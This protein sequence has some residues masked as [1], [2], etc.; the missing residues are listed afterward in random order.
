MNTILV[1]GASGYIAHHAILGLLDKGYAVRGTLRDMSREAEV[2]Q[3]VRIQRDDSQSDDLSFVWADMLENTGWDSAVEGVDAILHIASPIETSQPKDRDAYVPAARGGVLRLLEAAAS[4]GTVKKVVMTSSVAAVC[5]GRSDPDDHIYT[6][7]D[8]S[9]P[10]SDRTSP[11]ARSKTLAERAAWDFMRSN[12]PPFSLTTVLPGLVLG[13]VGS[14]DIGVSA[15]IV[16]RLMAGDTPGLPRLGWS[17]VDVRDVADQHILA[18]ENETANGERLLCVGEFLWMS[19]IATILR[20][21]FP[22]FAGTIPKRRL[23][24]FVLRGVGLFDPAARS[25]IPELGRAVT[26]SP[27]KA[28]ELLGWSTREVRDTVVATGQSLIDHGIVS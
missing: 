11:Y 27:A 20:T 28:R 17:I 16:R 10:E 24:D 1:T 26:C 9:D 12:E 4:S 25:L 23:P 5:E 8:W 19:E 14:S 15:E 6:E 7:S 21:A 18:L 13:P 22:D 2:R 3:S